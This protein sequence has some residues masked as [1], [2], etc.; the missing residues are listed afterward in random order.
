MDRKRLRYDRALIAAVCWSTCGLLTV[1]I[2][3]EV[4]ATTSIRSMAYVMPLLLCIIWHE[5]RVNKA[6]A[7]RRAI[8]HTYWSR[9]LLHITCAV[10][11]ATHIMF[12]TWAIL[13]PI[14]QIASFFNAGAILALTALGRWLD[15]APN[16]KEWAIV[17]VGFFGIVIVALAS[18]I[19]STNSRGAWLSVGAAVTLTIS[20]FCLKRR[21]MKGKR[22]T[23]AFES[24]ALAGTF[25]IFFYAGDLM[26][27]GMPSAR[28]MLFIFL[29]G[30]IATGV[31]DVLY[32][33]A[34]NGP[35]KMPVSHGMLVTRI[36]PVL[37]AVWFWLAFGKNPSG[38]QLL[39]AL[40]LTLAIVLQAI[41][42]DPEPPN[43]PT[44][45][46]DPD[47]AGDGEAV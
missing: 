23:E 12:M 27:E 21:T 46:G 32:I 31:G 22:G 14:G 47:I 30:A 3:H 45:G 4:R 11:S 10:F 16:K 25:L 19:L 41:V 40:V 1:L 37:T 42:R 43:K 39:G 35:P 36:S 9:N 6:G 26:R 18:G 7:L 29:L 20:Q 8:K 44:E 15:H 33:L 2:A 17:G 38:W 28:D 24:W 5:R 13:S 34:L